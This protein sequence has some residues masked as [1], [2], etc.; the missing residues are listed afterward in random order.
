MSAS[1]NLQMLDRT[2]NHRGLYVKLA[3]RMHNMRTINGHKKVAKRKLIAQETMDFF[4]PLARKLGLQEAAAEFE[5]MCL[6]VFKQ[7]E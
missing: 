6:A 1:E 7:Q 3:D 5:K 4:V 2:G